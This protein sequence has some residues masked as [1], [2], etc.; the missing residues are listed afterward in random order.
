MMRLQMAKKPRQLTLMHVRTSPEMSD[1]M[2]T[3]PVPR[4][5]C[6]LTRVSLDD[7]WHLCQCNVQ[8]FDFKVI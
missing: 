8:S 6:L 2:V 4:L 1:P 5:L 7:M 3:L